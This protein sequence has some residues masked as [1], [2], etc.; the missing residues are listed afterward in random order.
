MKRMSGDQ[1]VG[2]QQ[3]RDIIT[4]LSRTAEAVILICHADW[5]HAVQ[6]QLQTLGTVTTTSCSACWRVPSALIIHQP[7]WM[8]CYLIPGPIEPTFLIGRQ[9]PFFFNPPLRNFYLIVFSPK[10]H[11]RLK[12]ELP[13]ILRKIKI[14]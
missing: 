1:R 2:L 12:N 6:N 7:A 4:L 3:P 11:F 14:V 13:S 10:A 5:S 9:K 8:E